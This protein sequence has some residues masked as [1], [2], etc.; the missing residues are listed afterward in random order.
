MTGSYEPVK[1][2]HERKLELPEGIDDDDVRETVVPCKADRNT[3][4]Y[5]Y[6]IITLYKL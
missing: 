1:Y 3:L 6:I 5:L 4:L 2:L